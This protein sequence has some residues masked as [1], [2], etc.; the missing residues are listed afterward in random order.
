[1]CK[2]IGSVNG[3][4]FISKVNQRLAEIFWT[5]W[6]LHCVYH[7][8]S[9]GQAE[10]KNRTLKVTLTKLSLETGTDWV[11]LLPLTLF[12]FWA[13]NTP[14]HFNLTPFEILI[15]PPPPWPWL[16]TLPPTPYPP[17]RVT[18]QADKDLMAR[19]QVF[20]IRNY[21]LKLVPCIT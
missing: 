10:R 18:F 7:P 8:Q 21:G 4:V 17:P 6:K 12:L 1:M 13:C 11:V 14:Y 5:N 20:Q 9:S 3:P 16:L 2:V 15:E 19:L